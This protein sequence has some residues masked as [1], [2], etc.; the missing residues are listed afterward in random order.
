MNKFN[1]SFNNILSAKLNGENINHIKTTDGI[2]IKLAKNFNGYNSLIIN[3]NYGIIFLSKDFK[4]LKKI[5]RFKNYNGTTTKE[6]SKK[7]N[8]NF[9]SIKSLINKLNK[10]VNLIDTREVIASSNLIDTRSNKI[11][12]RSNKKYISYIDGKIIESSYSHEDNISNYLSKFKN[13]I[14]ED[15]IN[16]NLDMDNYIYSYASINKINNKLIINEYRNTSFNIIASKL[17]ETYP[18]CK[19]LFDNRVERTDLREIN[20]NNRIDLRKVNSCNRIDLR[21]TVNRIDLRKVAA[22]DVGDR[23]YAIVLINGKYF[24]TGETHAQAIQNFLENTSK[25][26]KLKDDWMRPLM[27]MS[28]DR[29]F[30]DEELEEA[31]DFG[32][33]SDNEFDTAVLNKY[34][35]SLAFAHYCDDDIEHGIFLEEYSLYNITLDQA[36]K[37][38]KSEYPNENIYNDDVDDDDETDCGYQLLANLRKMNKTADH[39]IYN[40]DYA[41]AIINGEIYEGNTHAEAVN[42]FLSGSGKS[43]NDDYGRPPIALRKL[44][45]A[46]DEDIEEMDDFFQDMY[47]MDREV[48][49]IAF[50]HVCNDAEEE[51]IFLE[52]SSLYNT[53]LEE[54]TKILKDKFPNYKIYNDDVRDNEEE[55]GYKLLAKLISN[56]L[57]KVSRLKKQADFYDKNNRNT[58]ILIINGEVLESQNGGEHYDL[59]KEYFKDKGL[60]VEDAELLDKEFEKTKF[61]MGSKVGNKIFFDVDVMISDSITEEEIESILKNKMPDCEVEFINY[62]ADAMMDYVDTYRK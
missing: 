42:K 62:D 38:F 8:R 26:F 46:T 25:K 36:V 47:T 55:V 21:K 12:M 45:D 22:H 37:A 10:N 61:A 20:S 19:I 31:V 15:I 49:S 41:V 17:S 51:G 40:R 5:A 48:K 56:N 11:D 39:D 30:T 43:L 59:I 27:P 2:A 6:A 54:A 35:D 18:N 29:F 60:D 1:T 57:V 33:L 14:A 4:E 28:D 9:G 58:A 23:D 34:I 52:Q 16:R 44:P 7:V 24:S 3:T 53:T 32:Y 13:Q 50:A